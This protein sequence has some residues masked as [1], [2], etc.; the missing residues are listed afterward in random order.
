L[1]IRRKED[2]SLALRL[3][4]NEALFLRGLAAELREQAEKPDFTK[5]IAQRLFPPYADDEKVND[6]LRQLLY[7]EQRRQKLDRVDL[8]SAALERIPSAGGELRLPPDEIERWLALLTDLRLMYAAIIGIED[9]SWSGDMDADHPPSREIL[10]Y[11]HLTNLQQ[12]LLDRG[13][14]I[15]FSG[16]WLRPS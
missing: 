16:G 9:D 10:V 5:R 4:G 3:G 8:F 12:M 1:K 11:L 2:G 6:E 7:E 14:G 13:F 15:G